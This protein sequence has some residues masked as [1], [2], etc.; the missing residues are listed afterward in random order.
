MVVS[1]K[2]WCEGKEMVEGANTHSPRRDEAPSR[3]DLLATE[4]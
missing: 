3:E 4:I 1:G 2:Y